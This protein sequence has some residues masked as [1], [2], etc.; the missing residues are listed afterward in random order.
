MLDNMHLE[1]FSQQL[2][3][4]FLIKREPAGAAVEVQL[5]EAQSIGS[6]PGYEQFSLLFRGPAN[7]YLEQSTYSFEHERLGTFE[8]FIVPVRREVDGFYYQA[9]INRLR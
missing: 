3:S 6:T 9:I 7:S 8:I 1:E 5:I 2:N 4:N